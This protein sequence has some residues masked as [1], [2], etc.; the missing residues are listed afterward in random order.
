MPVDQYAYFALSSY[1]TSAA[2]MTAVL[3]LEPDEKVIRGSHT[4]EPNAL[5]TT[6]RW[7]VVCRKPGLSVDEQ[8]ARVVERLTP[9]ADAIAA[10]ARRLDAEGPQGPSAVLQVVRCFSTG[11]DQ[12]DQPRSTDATTDP[13]NLF[14]W[15]LGR[16][17][18]DFLHATGAVLDV[19]EYDLTRNYPDDRSA[20]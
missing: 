14:G 10:L 16:D 3:G 15:H 19:D 2:E 8:I 20:R 13:P 4:L 18:L 11:S 7:K 9:H 12:Q 5:P 17:T 6:H 1:E